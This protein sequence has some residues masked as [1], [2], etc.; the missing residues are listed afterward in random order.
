MSFKESAKK[1]GNKVKKFWKEHWVEVAAVTGGVVIT[2][3]TCYGMYKLDQKH[4]ERALRD[5]LDESAKETEK[6]LGTIEEKT[7][8]NKDW[9][10]LGME[11]EHLTHQPYGDMTA[12]DDHYVDPFD[13]NCFI[14]AG[15]NSLYNDSPDQL[16]FY[17]LD[18]E[19]WYHRMPDSNYSA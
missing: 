15:Y 2:G 13:G 19:G 6:Y 18:K 7:A 9:D 16:A 1:F 5:A 10:E 12:D 14:I 4:A 11:L 8:W 3:A 17:A